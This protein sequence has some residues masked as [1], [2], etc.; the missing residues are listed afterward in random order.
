MS[1]QGNRLQQAPFI[2]ILL[3]FA[4]GIAIAEWVLPPKNL[5]WWIL[6]ALLILFLVFQK[7]LSKQDFS[8]FLILLIFLS[9]GL[10]WAVHRRYDPKELP[11]GVYVAVL[12]EF[13][14]KKA[15]SYRAEAELAGS[16]IKILVY[17]EKSEDFFTAKPGVFFCFKGK[18]QLITNAGNPYEFNYR[19][20]ALRNNIGHRIYLKQKDYHFSGPVKRKWELRHEAL[21]VRENF[22]NKL[23]NTGI[24]GE[25]FRV[26]S[27]ITLGARDNLDPETTRSFTRT[28]TLHVLAVSGGNVAVVYIFLY[29]IFGFLNK[30][31]KKGSSYLQH[32]CLLGFY[33]ASVQS[34]TDV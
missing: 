4:C 20:Y 10:S 3:Y 13:P 21:R 26:I 14:L 22:L 24:T 32:S 18:P 2:R 9:L 8:G 27:A 33:F 11:Y 1:N 28:G 15:N 34:L 31:Q 17:F 7:K 12:D 6:P 5:L 16:G 23:Q 29:L 19:K 30:R 25:T